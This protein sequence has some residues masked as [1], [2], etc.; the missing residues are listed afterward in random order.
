MR[1]MKRGG[2]VKAIADAVKRGD[3]NWEAGDILLKRQ[4]GKDT[5]RGRKQER[6]WGKTDSTNISTSSYTHA[7]AHTHTNTRTHTH[8]HTTEQTK[9]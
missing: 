7:H 8:T 2:G 6:K 4:E 3:G 5:N 9:T 1:R